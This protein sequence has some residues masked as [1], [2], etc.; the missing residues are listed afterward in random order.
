VDTYV[1]QSQLLG[2]VSE[3]DEDEE[4]DA[5]QPRPWARLVSLSDAPPVELMLPPI[6][7]DKQAGDSHLG[8]HSLGRSNKCSLIFK[9]KLISNEHCRLYCMRNNDGQMCPYIEDHS[10]NG[11]FV[12]RSTRLLKGMIC[13][14]F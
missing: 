2:R 5:S 14:C 11:T 8:L 4:I 9:Q 12:N 6:Q 7:Q 10:A 13:N 1:E 3:G